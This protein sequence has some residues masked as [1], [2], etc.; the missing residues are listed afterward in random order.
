MQGEEQKWRKIC[1]DIGR[2]W[3]IRD[4]GVHGE[5]IH[6]LDSKDPLTSVKPQ[7]A[8]TVFVFSEVNFGGSAQGK[9]SYNSVPLRK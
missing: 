8:I 6:S 5:T 2:A 1:W 9:G 3:I 7:S 4:P